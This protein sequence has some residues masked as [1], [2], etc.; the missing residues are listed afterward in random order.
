MK[1]GVARRL[2]RAVLG[3]VLLAVFWHLWVLGNVLAWTVVP[4]TGTSFMRLRAVESAL[5][6]IPEQQ[7]VPYEKIA[8]PVIRAVIAAED[9]RFMEHSGFDW[10]AMRRAF[11]RNRRAGGAVAGGSTISQQLAKNLFL[12]SSRSYLRKA[13]EALITVALETFWSKRRI[14]EVYLN[15]VEWG[16][17]IFGIG[18]AARHYYRLPPQALDAADAARLAVMLPNPRRYEERFT[19]RLREHAGRV[20]QRMNKSEIP[21]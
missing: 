20:R 12:S 6:V 10:Q 2:R 21:E 18:A 7:W 13:E 3:V 9:D 17:G 19:P 1:K 4:V 5:T 14:I 15:V 11:D 8:E 16:E